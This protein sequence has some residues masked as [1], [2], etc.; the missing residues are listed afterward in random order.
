MES[1]Y[2]YTLNQGPNMMA[3]GLMGFMKERANSHGQM[4][5]HSQENGKIAEKMDL[6]LSKGQ[7]EFFMREIGKIASITAVEN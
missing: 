4:D 7:T 5:P 6:V 3:N 1:V 2:I